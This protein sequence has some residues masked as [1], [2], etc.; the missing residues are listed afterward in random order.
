MILRVLNPLIIEFS[1]V[2]NI[3]KHYFH[4][5]FPLI[6]RVSLFLSHRLSPLLIN[7]EFSLAT[8]LIKESQSKISKAKS[9]TSF[10]RE[11]E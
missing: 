9:V 8:H 7:R 2:R 3:L 11:E 1:L 10:V 6:T 4:A 5:T